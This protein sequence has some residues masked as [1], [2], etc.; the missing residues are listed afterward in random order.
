VAKRVGTQTFWL[1]ADR[2]GSIQAITDATGAEVQRRTYRSYGEKIADSTSHVESR[3]W[4][5]Q[6]QD[7][8]D[9]TYLHARYYDPALGIFLSPDPAEADLNTY[10]YAYGDPINLAD[11]CGLDPPCREPGHIGAG[12]VCTIDIPPGDGNGGNGD[13]EFV[14]GGPGPGGIPGNT[15]PGQPYCITCGNPNTPPPQGGWGYDWPFP[16]RAG[17]GF[18]GGG[19]AGRGGS[20]TA[21]GTVPGAPGGGAPGDSPG[22]PGGGLGPLLIGSPFGTGAG[23]SGGHGGHGSAAVQGAVSS[24]VDSARSIG[25]SLAGLATL[26]SARVNAAYSYGPLGQTVDAQW[27]YK[28]TT[29]GALG[30]SAVAGTLAGGL[31]FAEWLGI[32][33]VGSATIGWRGGEITL[34]FPGRPT[35]DWRFNPFGGHGWPPH[36]HRRPGIRKHRPWQGGW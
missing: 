18:P 35:P 16:S 27:Q 13:P 2:L 28:W 6:R 1:H 22:G 7:E 20:G 36:Y 34:T 11:R 31:G 30:V 14:P 3:G 29:R 25:N 21:P 23:G 19:R 5:D 32:S 4:I 24:V 9:L 17:G 15:F 8:T 10:A 33:E 26:D 12:G